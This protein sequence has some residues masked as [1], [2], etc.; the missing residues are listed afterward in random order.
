M[1]NIRTGTFNSKDRNKKCPVPIKSLSAA[2]LVLVAF[3]MDEEETHVEIKPPK[4]QELNIWNDGRKDEYVTIKGELDTPRAKFVQKEDGLA[5]FKWEPVDNTERVQKEKHS[6]RI[7]AVPLIM[8]AM[9]VD[10]E[11]RSNYADLIMQ[12]PSHRWVVMRR[13]SGAEAGKLRYRKTKEDTERWGQYEEKR[14][15]LILNSITLKW[16][17][18]LTQS[19]DQ[20]LKAQ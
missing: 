10:K 12:V 3:D 13:T 16:L 1:K 4:Y 2:C 17:K 7:T 11:E 6:K 19:M 18:F 9:Y 8:V 20:Q 5:S 14:I 15:C